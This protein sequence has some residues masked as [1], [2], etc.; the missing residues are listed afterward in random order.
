MVGKRNE[1]HDCR[2]ASGQIG[3]V[4]RELFSVVETEIV[5]HYWISFGQ[6][7]LKMTNTIQQSTNMR[8]EHCRKLNLRTDTV[9]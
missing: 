8:K 4:G 3:A 1:R 5:F 7:K 6:S 2:L 9:N